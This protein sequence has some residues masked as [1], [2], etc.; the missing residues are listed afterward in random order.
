MSDCYCINIFQDSHEILLYHENHEIIFNRDNY[1]LKSLSLTF[2]DEK[3]YSLRYYECFYA[4]TINEKKILKIISEYMRIKYY[5]E[6]E[7]IKVKYSFNQDFEEIKD[8]IENFNH[9]GCNNCELNNYNN[10]YFLKSQNYGLVITGEVHKKVRNDI[11][12]YK[13]KI[14]ILKLVEKNNQCEFT[15]SC[16]CNL[17]FENKSIFREQ[18]NKCFNEDLKGDEITSFYNFGNLLN[19]ELY[20]GNHFQESYFFIKNKK[21]LLRLKIICIYF[22]IIYYTNIKYK[23]VNKIVY[24]FSNKKLNKNKYWYIIYSPKYG[25]DFTHVIF[26]SLMCIHDIENLLYEAIKNKNDEYNNKIYTQDFFIN[27]NV[28]YS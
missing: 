18:I 14:N 1:G 24:K 17:L 2:Q 22:R 13:E 20:E 12:K 26:P 28:F 27:N 16:L 11:I 25:N 9:E 6:V 23:C 19:I 8:I 7:S 5:D 10:W 15:S 21:D 4:E 3:D